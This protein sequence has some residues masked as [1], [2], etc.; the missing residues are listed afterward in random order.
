MA[1]GHAVGGQRTHQHFFA[2]MRPEVLVDP[3]TTYSM[4]SGHSSGSFAFFIALAI[5]AGREQPQR[6]RITWV[7]LGCLLAISVALSRVYLGAHWPTDIMAGAL[8]AILVNAFALALSQRYMP[9]QPIPQKIWWLILPAI[10][11]LYGFFMLHDL[12]RELLRYTY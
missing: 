4:P 10:V 3:L 6:M 8:L 5:L 7:L 2:R 12:S 11:A 1:A 9:L